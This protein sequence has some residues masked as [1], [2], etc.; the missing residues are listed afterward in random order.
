MPPIRDHT[1]LYTF[2]G[3][4][5]DDDE[6]DAHDDE[7]GACIRPARCIVL[8][9]RLYFLCLSSSCCSLY[10]RY[11]GF[12]HTNYPDTDMPP[13]VDAPAT[14]ESMMS[15]FDFSGVTFDGAPFTPMLVYAPED[16]EQRPRGRAASRASA[17]RAPSYIPRP[18][19]A[20]ILFR[21]SFIRSQNVPGRVEGN[22]STLSKIIGKYWHAL[23]PSE[24]AR[25][26]DKARAAQ[27]EHRRRY[28]D[29]RFRPG[30]SSGGNAHASGSGNG[31][32]KGRRKGRIKDGGGDDEPEPLGEDDAEE[33]E[34]DKGKGRGGEKDK[35][36]GK[37]KDGEKWKGSADKGKGAADKGKGNADKGK[38]GGDK[39][40]DTEKGGKGKGKAREVKEEDDER[41]Q[42]ITDLLV[43]GK[44]GGELA[45]AVE[46]WEWEARGRGRGLARVRRGPVDDDHKAQVQQEEY[47][48][49][50]Q[51]EQQ[52][53]S[54]QYQQ[55]Y[56]EQG[57]EDG[58]YSPVQQPPAS[59]YS[60]LAPASPSPYSPFASPVLAHAAAASLSLS[61]SPVPAP[62]HA[63]STLMLPPLTHMYKRSLSAPCAARAPLDQELDLTP[64]P[65]PAPYVPPPPQGHVR[66]DTVSAFPV[67]RATYPPAYVSPPHRHPQGHVRRES[68]PVHRATGSAF[69]AHRATYPPPYAHAYAGGP[70]PAPRYG[71]A[72]R[73]R[74]WWER[75]RGDDGDAV[76]PDAGDAEA[77]DDAD[78]DADAGWA[79][80]GLP[81]FSDAY[82]PSPSPPLPYLKASGTANIGAA[83]GAGG[84]PYALPLPLS[85]VSDAP[86]DP[87]FR[88]PP[89]TAPAISS[90]ST[91]S[92]WA[93]DF[94]VSPPASAGAGVSSFGA[95]VSGGGGGAGGSAGGGR[96]SGWYQPPG[97]E[98]GGAW[99]GHE[100]GYAPPPLKTP[101][102]AGQEWPTRGDVEMYD[103][104]A[105]AWGAHSRR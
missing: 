39:G 7:D 103:A 28:P 19:N 27:A 94:S 72:A 52:P 43:A 92:G 66:R 34:G 36:K 105:G 5:D 78:A 44:K 23:P 2:L 64:T 96:T 25:W 46:E 63:A 53:Y 29:W 6:H 88:F 14:Q 26:E 12:V 83:G 91:L 8:I 75:A 49:V 99:V 84:D 11:T 40:R 16:A 1:I 85:P 86:E 22:H 67:H 33:P 38:G 97:W 73:A 54:P 35:G 76:Y 90:F 50:V 3:D 41:S 51:Q 68:F 56:Q 74:A 79:D 9:H 101:Y 10:N 45:R 58:P 77:G 69:P 21:S 65:A 57:Y 18:P 4:E 24:R 47:A 61:A 87:R 55:Q 70:G 31:K 32:P 60:P 15:S 71:G 48:P 20:F 81:A 100:G 59:P 80:S 42:K 30:N 13:L 37:E 82:A 104:G 17:K 102:G 93:G 62:A 89:A 98:A 95:S